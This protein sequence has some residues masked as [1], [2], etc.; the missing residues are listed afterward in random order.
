MYDRY[1]TFRLSRHF[2]DKMASNC[3]FSKFKSN[4]I[5]IALIFLCV[6]EVSQARSYAW[7]PLPDPL[8]VCLDGSQYGLVT[9]IGT[10][11]IKNWTLSFQGGGWCY[12]EQDCHS[13]S[14]TPLGSS[15]TWPA[16]AANDTCNAAPGTAQVNL[17]YGDGAS[18]TGFREA[19]WPVPGNASAKLYFRG[20]RNLES[21]LDYLFQKY[22]LASAELLIVSGGS[23]GGLSTFLHLDRVV[24]RM[25]TAQSNARIVGMPICGFFIDAPNDGYQPSN[26][27]YPLRMQYVYNMQNSSGS[28]SPECQSAYGAEA[29]KCIMAPHAAKFVRTPWFALQ[30]RFDTWQLGNIAML[31]C[32]SN[33][34]KCNST[35]W[36]QMQAYGPEFMEQ[37]LPY[38]TPESHNGAFL[39]ACL[40]HGSTSSTI[41]GLRNYQAFE[42]WLAG[43][44]TNGNWWIMKC[45]GSETAGPCDRASVCEPFPQ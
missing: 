35:E 2:V 30:S 5:V 19:A 24:E 3:A 39:D 32:T 13:R 31:P 17:W 38:V 23:A 16:L 40:I 18:F 26:V 36:A 25:R 29:W 42:S 33:P 15:H 45:N 34:L 43:N 1:D 10:G 20:A 27:T 44:K 8:A 37:F 9:C 28:L 6:V 41:N 4:I 11:P 21:S 7:E 22:D 14:L 12:N